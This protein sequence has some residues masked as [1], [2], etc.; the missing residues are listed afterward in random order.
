M[1]IDYRKIEHIHNSSKQKG[2]IA[3]SRREYCCRL[4]IAFTENNSIKCAVDYIPDR[5]RENSAHCKDKSD[6]CILL[7][8]RSQ[9]PTYGSYSKDP[10]D[11][12]NKF[13]GLASHL[14]SKGHS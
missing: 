4:V 2:R 9:K 8:K 6:I 12:Q 7:Y 11:A 13:S 1:R 10:E 14:H 3:S 5:T